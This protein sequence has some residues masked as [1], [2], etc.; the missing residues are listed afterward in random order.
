[1]QSGFI[2]ESCGKIAP[3]LVD[4]HAESPRRGKRLRR[5]PT[6]KAADI[7]HQSHG[8]RGAN[9]QQHRGDNNPEKRGF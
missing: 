9:P 7:F 2:D 1:M 3:N 6:G 8:Q 4:L 5:A